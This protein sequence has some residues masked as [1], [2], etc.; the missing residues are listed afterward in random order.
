MVADA[1][2]IGVGRSQCLDPIEKRVSVE[3][4]VVGEVI[5]CECGA[6][7]GCVKSKKE[8]GSCQRTLPKAGDSPKSPKLGAG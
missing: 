7:E 1:C 2:H 8:G 6:N 5:G 3:A 4:T